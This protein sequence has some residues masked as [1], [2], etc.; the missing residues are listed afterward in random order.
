MTPQ[1][2]VKDGYNKDA[3]V[4]WVEEADGAEPVAFSESELTAQ[5]VER[6]MSKYMADE[7]EA[8]DA[9]VI[10]ETS[11]S[12]IAEVLPPPDSQREGAA[13]HVASSER[14]RLLRELAN[15][16]DAGHLTKDEFE[17]EKRR[18]C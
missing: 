17:A 6:F 8:H 2:F 11:T 12:V 16:Y 4:T 15:L 7:E 3:Q 18:L 1:D 10:E 9:P 5:R 14:V 13:P